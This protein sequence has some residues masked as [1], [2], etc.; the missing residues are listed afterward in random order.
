M[1]LHRIRAPVAPVKLSLKDS[2]V[3]LAVR[4]GFEPTFRV[5]SPLPRIASS[6]VFI[7]L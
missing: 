1:I 3:D 2:V 4:H 6:R 7:A 5:F